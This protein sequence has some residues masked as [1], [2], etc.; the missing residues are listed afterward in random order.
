[1]AKKFK[2]KVQVKKKRWIK[3]VSPDGKDLGETYVEDAETIIGKRVKANLMTYSGSPRTR[4]YNVKFIVTSVDSDKANTKLYGYETQTT[5]IKSSVRKGCDRVDHR[6]VIKTKN[7]EKIIMKPLILTKSNVSAAIRTA[8]REVFDKF[9]V[10]KAKTCSADQLLSDVIAQK[11]QRDVKKDLSK[12]Y[13]IKNINIKKM[14]V[15]LDDNFSIKDDVE[16]SENAEDADDV[17]VVND[18]ESV[19]DDD[20]QTE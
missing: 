16:D 4:R 14:Y 10:E 20:A 2:K 7:N 5:A 18:E 19:S 1:M 6:V 15:V 17:E 12:V 8:I 9:I 13:P 3:I 11:L